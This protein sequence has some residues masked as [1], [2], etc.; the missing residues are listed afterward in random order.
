MSS[1]SHWRDSG[2]LERTVATAGG[3]EAFEAAVAAM[4][5][6]A[7]GWRLAEMGSREPGHKPSHDFSTVLII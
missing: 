3:Q 6:D 4:L 1:A 5:D 7:H 2:H